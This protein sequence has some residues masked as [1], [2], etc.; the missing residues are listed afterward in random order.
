VA[1]PDRELAAEVAAACFDGSGHCAFTV[2]DPERRTQLLEWAPGWPALRWVW[3]M[4]GDTLR[5]LGID[6]QPAAVTSLAFHASG[7][8]GLPLVDLV[9]RG[10]WDLSP[11]TALAV[12]AWARLW[13]EAVAVGVAGA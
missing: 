5:L 2:V 12:R 7:G 8:V 9:E 10:R 6:D 4:E 3:A 13:A 1:C 11:W